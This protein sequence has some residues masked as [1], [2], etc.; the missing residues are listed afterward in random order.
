[1]ILIAH[2]I[3][4]CELQFFCVTLAQEILNCYIIIACRHHAPEVNHPW[5]NRTFYTILPRQVYVDKT[6]MQIRNNFQ[7]IDKCSQSPWYPL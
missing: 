5:D 6:I 4:T 2:T 3:I 7:L 1:M